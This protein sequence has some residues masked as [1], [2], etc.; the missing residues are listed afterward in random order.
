MPARI[1]CRQR[2]SLALCH[3]SWTLSQ[4]VR[5]STKYDEMDRKRFQLNGRASRTRRS[6]RRTRAWSTA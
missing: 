2:L 3:L 4:I 6:I 5:L 1:R